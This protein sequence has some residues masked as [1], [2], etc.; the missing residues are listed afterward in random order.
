MNNDKIII[1][2]LAVVTAVLAASLVYYVATYEPINADQVK[3]IDILETKIEDHISTKNTDFTLYLTGDMKHGDILNIG[4]TVLTPNSS[5]TGMIYHGGETNPT[6][7][8]VFQLTADEYG[9]YTHDVIINDEYLWT[10]DG[11]YTVSIQ[12][13]GKYKEIEFHRNW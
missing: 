8:T 9:S 7:V 1:V 4:G 12:N 6:I 11:I 5:I 2:I 3:E 10:Q 13:G